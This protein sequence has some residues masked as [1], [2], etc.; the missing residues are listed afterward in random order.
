MKITL[1]IVAEMKKAEVR[2]AQQQDNC[3][4]NAKCNGC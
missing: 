4:K 1:H 3:I 2:V